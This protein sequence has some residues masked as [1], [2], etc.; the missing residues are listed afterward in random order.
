MRGARRHGAVVTPAECRRCV[1]ARRYVNPN[2]PAPS[3]ASLGG[4]VVD[5]FREWVEYTYPGSRPEDVI[6]NYTR[7]TRPAGPAPGAKLD[8]YEWARS[9]SSFLKV[10]GDEDDAAGARPVIRRVMEETRPRDALGERVPAAGGFLVPERLRRQVFAYM[11]A[12]VVRPRATVVQMDSLR[13]PVPVLDNPTSAGSAQALGGLTFAMAEEGAGITPTAPSFSRLALEAHKAAAYLQGV[14]NEL[15]DDSPA[16]GDF[17]ARIIAIG[18]QWM[19]DDLF[20]YTGTGTGEPQALVNAPGGLT[21][22]RSGGAGKVTHLDIVT[23]LK[24]LHPA[25]K[26]TA[27]WLL[28]EDAFDQL[29]EL[30][31]IVGTPPA[32]SNTTPPQALKFNSQSGCWELLG[33]PAEVVDHQPPVGTQGD[34]MLCDLSLFLIGD[35]QELTIERSQRGTGFPGSMSNF[36]IKARIDGRYWPQSTFTLANNKVVAPLVV[37]Q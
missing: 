13:V 24:G 26:T 22:S 17:I 36:R 20:V 5:D 9:W 29:L 2:R 7:L 3:V 11:T 16:L 30:Y 8:G 23:M 34:V 14:P 1:I 19:E 33:L 18:Y 15:I 35:R 25:S 28:G 31:E 32:G 21:V 12:A 6:A 27:T 4:R 37:L 10:I